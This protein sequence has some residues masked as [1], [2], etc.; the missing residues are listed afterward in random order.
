[1]LPPTVSVLVIEGST[2]VDDGEIV[3]IVVS[4]EFIEVLLE[5][6]MSAVELVVLLLGESFIERDSVVA[7]GG[8]GIWL[9]EH[10]GEAMHVRGLI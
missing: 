10:L 9:V 3:V 4:H 2:E 5:E 1:M 6:N 8:D 7:I